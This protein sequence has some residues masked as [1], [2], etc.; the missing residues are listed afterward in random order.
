MNAVCQC[1]LRVWVGTAK[2]M[3]SPTHTCYAFYKYIYM[4]SRARYVR[5]GVR[6]GVLSS[7][8]GSQSIG[9][10]ATTRA[11]VFTVFP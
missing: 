4:C 3:C 6:V 10:A 9:L 7:L 8:S 2:E 5:V 1:V 11:E